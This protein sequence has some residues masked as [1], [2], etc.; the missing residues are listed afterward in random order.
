MPVNSASIVTG[1]AARGCATERVAVSVFSSSRTRA[2]CVRPPDVI[3]IDWNVISAA[4]N[5]TAVVGCVT[6][7]S[8]VARPRKL[9]FWKSGANDSA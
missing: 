9:S 6:C 2:S 7:T 5:V 8:M 1:P 3:R 4:C